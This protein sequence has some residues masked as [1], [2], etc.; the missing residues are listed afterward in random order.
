MKSDA[1]HSTPDNDTVETP[2]WDAGH[3][4]GCGNTSLRTR[5]RFWRA[6]GR[7]YKSV[8][9]QGAM[10]IGQGSNTVIPQIFAKHLAV[11]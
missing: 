7:R 5:R 8:L 2:A 9:H 4:S 11:G 10:D 1:A 3:G 6:C